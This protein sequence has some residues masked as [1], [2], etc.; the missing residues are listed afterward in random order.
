MKTGETLE[1][2]SRQAFRSWLEENH[3]VKSEIWLIYPYKHS[4]KQKLSYAESVEEALCFGWID[5]QVKRMDAER[6][7]RRFSPR[8]RKSHWSESNK[9]RALKALRE[10]SMTEAGLAQLPHDVVAAWEETRQTRQP[11]DDTSQRG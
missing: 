6:F 10:G 2:E 9:Q 8:R 4:G 11:Q 3:E 7:V 5:G 1:V